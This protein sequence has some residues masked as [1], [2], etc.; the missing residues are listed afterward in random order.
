MFSGSRLGSL[1]SAG[2]GGQEDHVAG[3]EARAR[4]GLA[5]ASSTRVPKVDESLVVLIRADLD[6]RP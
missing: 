1:P 2:V 5:E 6:D 4:D 3:L